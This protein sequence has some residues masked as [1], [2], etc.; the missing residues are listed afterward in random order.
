MFLMIDA[1][2]GLRVHLK[3]CSDSI[4]AFRCAVSKTQTQVSR[5]PDQRSTSVPPSKAAAKQ[6]NCCSRSMN[7]DAGGPCAPTPGTGPRPTWRWLVG[8]W[9]SPA[10]SGT[11]GT[12]TST[13]P[14]RCCRMNLVRTFWHFSY[15]SLDL[16]HLLFCTQDDVY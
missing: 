2:L 6:T 4:K 11:S 9:A 13:T 12:S 16:I 8:S 3:I 5:L 7:L 14:S 10:A 15:K 1:S